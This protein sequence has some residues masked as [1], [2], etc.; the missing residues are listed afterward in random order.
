MTS[1]VV[2]DVTAISF[3]ANALGFAIANIAKY[4]DGTRMRSTS[5]PTRTS[6]ALRLRRE[7][8]YHLTVIFVLVHAA[9]AAKRSPSFVSWCVALP[10]HAS[11]ARGPRV[12]DVQLQVH[13]ARRCVLFL[14]GVISAECVAELE[15][16][17]KVNGIE[18]GLPVH[19]QYLEN[20]V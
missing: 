10:R 12:E 2:A 18:L 19:I 16:N 8:R 9:Q 3:I 1:A 15:A 13:A 7:T 20:Y 6:W 4:A 5:C 11:E 14:L 17:P